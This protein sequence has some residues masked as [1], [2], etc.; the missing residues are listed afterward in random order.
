[1]LL[2]FFLFSVY[3][4]WIITDT[5]R[6]VEAQGRTLEELEWIYQQPNPVKASQSVD[7]VVVQSDGRVIEKINDDDA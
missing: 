6:S 2:C 7:R 5:I 4:S 3:D 1:L